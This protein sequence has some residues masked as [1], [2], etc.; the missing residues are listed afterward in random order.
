[1]QK[2][3]KK[4]NENAAL[5]SMFDELVNEVNRT[6]SQYYNYKIPFY[7]MTLGKSQMNPSLL[8][9]MRSSPTSLKQRKTKKP[10]AIIKLWQ[11][12]QPRERR[13]FMS[14]TS[15]LLL[16]PSM[17]LQTDNCSKRSY[18]RISKGTRVT[19]S[20]ILQNYGDSYT[21][22]TIIYIYPYNLSRITRSPI[23]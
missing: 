17:V 16:P 13:I 4:E 8:H 5:L 22:F 18:Q 9:S 3:M 6:A 12:G 23:A 11:L 14:N 1:M 2:K 21:Q 10:S 15:N 20:G 7:N 19:K